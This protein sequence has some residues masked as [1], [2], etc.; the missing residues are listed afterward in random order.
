MMPWLWNFLPLMTDKNF[1]FTDQLGYTRI[2]AL[3]E[4]GNLEPETR[5]PE[6]FI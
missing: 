6:P 4:R 5:A 1:N 2:D 3:W